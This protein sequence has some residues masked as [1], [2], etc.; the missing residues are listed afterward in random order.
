[1]SKSYL[2]VFHG[3]YG[4]FC[5][6][7]EIVDISDD[8]CFDAIPTW[9]IC[10]PPTRK[11]VEIGSKLFFVAYY[12][13]TKKYYLKGWFEVAEKISYSDA[14]KRF[15]LRKNVIISRS[16]RSVG[17]TNWRYTKLKNIYEGIYGKHIPYWLKSVVVKEGT[18]HQNNV[19]THE[20]DN[21]KCRR[22]FH[23]DKDQFRKCI[24]TNLCEKSNFSLN[25]FENY[26]VSHP[27]N[28]QDTGNLMIEF[29]KFKEATG[30]DFELATPKGQ[31]NV[32]LIDEYLNN[33]FQFFQ[34]F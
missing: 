9:G 6:Q 27:N 19:D 4:K 15:P 20:I 7:K 31:H 1:M 32:R 33:F 11:S 14:L 26:I 8:P 21:W 13:E 2:I 23:C 22:I 16:T 30:I 28:W 34:Q 25:Q 3:D 18:F 17:N 24:D 12:K 5:K 10:R 29:S